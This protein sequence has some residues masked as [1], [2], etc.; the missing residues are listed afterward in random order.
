MYGNPLAKETIEK[1]RSLRSQGYSLPEISQLVATPK[2]TVF[3][4][5]QGVEIL[6]EY[7]ANW[8]GK[9]GG[10]KKKKLLEERKALEEGKEIVEI[11]SQK[12]KLLFI[13]A[14]YWAEGSKRDFSL[15]NTDPDLIRLFVNGL[16]DIFHI[17]DERFRISVRIY[18]DLDRG[19]C[20]S[21]W[22]DIVDV[23]VKH[24]VGVNILKGKKK[25][26]LAYGMCRVRVTKGGLLLKKLVGINK[27]MVAS[28]SL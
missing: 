13:A 21:Y 26:K 20:L 6:P 9:R 22:S 1:I 5:I 14:L 16:R 23:P 17:S 4:Y 12:E 28:L 10:S 3:R 15:S 19:K 25:G 2:T 7:L 8:A 27:A 11:P 24:F 18:E